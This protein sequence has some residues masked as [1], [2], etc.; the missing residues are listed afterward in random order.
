MHTSYTSIDHNTRMHTFPFPSSSHCIRTLIS[1]LN[2]GLLSDYG[3]IQSTLRNHNSGE[4]ETHYVRFWPA[5]CFSSRQ[6]SVNVPP[7]AVMKNVKWGWCFTQEPS[8]HAGPPS[9]V[10][11]VNLKQSDLFT[12]CYTL[13]PWLPSVGN[14]QKHIPGTATTHH[15]LLITL[16]A[17][18]I[19]QHW[20]GWTIM[21]GLLE[22]FSHARK[23]WDCNLMRPFCSNKSI[24][25][26]IFLER[27]QKYNKKYNF[28]NDNKGVWT[29]NIIYT[30]L[31]H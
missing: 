17:V 26:L 3:I 8:F 12:N 29:V 5:S 18:S 21:K 16:H 15:P 28:F 30:K 7:I 11:W 9:V 31:Q 14:K 13:G 22:F 2:S 24:N 23:N 4:V 1:N 27:R 6:S 19:K 10:K 20:M 25:S